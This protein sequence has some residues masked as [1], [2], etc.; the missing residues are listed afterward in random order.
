MSSTTPHT[1]S[2]L[3]EHSAAEI[4]DLDEYDN[5]DDAE[6]FYAQHSKQSATTAK[7][8]TTTINTVTQSMSTI[9]INKPVITIIPPN[10]TIQ[11]TS[12]DDDTAS[13]ASVQSHITGEQND[14]ITGVYDEVEIEDMQ[15]DSA[16]QLYTYPCP[17]GDKFVISRGELCDGEDIARCPSCTLIIRVIYDGEMFEDE[18][19]ADSSVDD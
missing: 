14:P 2:T 1:A 15:Y 10:N 19:E 16:T 5:L 4:I 11:T 6:S 18:K 8:N 13:V 3:F 9:T 12:E 17:C 7:Q